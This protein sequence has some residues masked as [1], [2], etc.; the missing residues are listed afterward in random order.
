MSRHFHNVL[1]ALR[2][3]AREIVESPSFEETPPQIKSNRKYYPFFANC[4]GAID[5]TH[6]SASIPIAK[7]VPYRSGRNNEISQNVLAA[8]S[9]D[10]CFTY[11]W[12]GWEGTAHDNRILW[13]AINT[14]RVKFPHPPPGIVLYFKI[15][16]CS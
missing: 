3:F 11:I 12:A 10:M 9:F 4:I 6:I 5:G 2:T 16:S 7:Q 1:E 13:E 15:F 14:P 8:C